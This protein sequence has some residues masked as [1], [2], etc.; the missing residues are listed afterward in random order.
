MTNAF[1][2][3]LEQLGEDSSDHAP[4]WN[5]APG[6]VLMGTLIETKQV[7]T[8][9]GKAPLAV[10]EKPEGARVQVWLNSTVIASEWAEA[11][12]MIGGRV[13]IRFEG[14]RIS[15]NGFRYKV[16]KVAAE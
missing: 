10:I 13:A 3:L 16:F 7:D 8:R 12:P 11:D 15:D 2:D 1:A 6:D 9:Y 14:E 4:T 5:P